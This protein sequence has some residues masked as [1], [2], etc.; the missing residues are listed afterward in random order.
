MRYLRFSIVPLIYTPLLIV[1]VFLGG[2][3]V[4]Y[5]ALFIVMSYFLLDMFSDKT[6]L[7]QKPKLP[8]VLD[9][10][11]YLHVFQSLLVVFILTWVASEDD[12]MNLSAFVYQHLEIDILPFKQKSAGELV[13]AAILCGFVL[14]INM[15]VGHELTHRTNS[16]FDCM[17]GNL[18]LSVVGDSQFSISHIYCHHK[19]VATPEDAASARRGESIYHFILRSS[20]G[21]YRESWSYEKDRLK[22]AGQAIIGPNNQLLRGMLLTLIFALTCLYF[23]GMLSFLLYLLLCLVSKLTYESTNYIQHYGL[24]RVP[25]ESVRKCH[26]WDCRSAFS[27]SALLNLTRHS[28]HHES[29]RKKYWELESAADGLVITNGYIVQIIRALVPF[30]WF[31]YMEK[32]LSTWEKTQ[33]TEGEIQIIKNEGKKV[34]YV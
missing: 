18:S 5:M 9:L 10:M 19:N 11:L 29:P 13:S 27:S 8:F 30:Y 28:A 22:K 24:V 6:G 3:N 1:S 32:K 33:A 4:G 17:I 21:Q 14:S 20:I 2:V 26:S 23:G 16:K 12:L 7:P 31:R 34:E 15:V 25:G